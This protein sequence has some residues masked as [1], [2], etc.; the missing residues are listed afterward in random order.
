MI[1]T[2]ILS[3]VVIIGGL[4]VFLATGLE[5]GVAIGVMAAIGMVLF[6]DQPLQQFI[7]TSFGTLNSFTLTCVP[8]YVMMGTLFAESGAIREMFDGFEK[9]LG[10]LRGG[11]VFAVLGAS[12]LFGAMS[13]SSVAAAATFGSIAFPDMAK[14][15]YDAKLSLG[16]IAMGGTLSV[17]IPPSVI[18]VIYGVWQGVSVAR[19]YAAAIIPGVILTVLLILQAFLLIRLRPSLAPKTSSYGL[20]ERLR[21]TIGII[22]WLVIIVLMLGVI[23]GGIMTP[24]EAA[25]LGAFLAVVAATAYRK[26]SFKA[27]QNSAL[28]ALKVSSMIALVVVAA[29]VM[30]HVFQ[31]TGFIDLLA[32]FVLHLRIGEYVMLAI[33]CLMYL[34]LGC[35]FDSI[36]MLVLTMPFVVPIIEGL[37]LDFT[38]WGV[39]YVILAEVGLITPPFGLVLFT[40][41]NVVPKEYSTATIALATAPFIIPAL[42]LIA[43]LI[44]FP[45][46]CLW[47]PKILSG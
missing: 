33:L 14:R 29:N 45:Q 25:A 15:G 4:L 18:L 8:L 40:L 20:G 42:V 39:V 41:R 1:P 32:S 47:L 44:A 30:A 36:S 23:F 46:L 10:G 24:T 37:G 9:L 38:W 34:I 16:I 22:P 28:T 3:V 6:T 17:L 21:A 11:L 27:L 2:S 43:L 19:L 5:I 31:F 12:A 35:F 7:W 13:G 26:M